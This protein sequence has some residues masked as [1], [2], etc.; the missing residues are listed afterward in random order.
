M[1]RI[2]DH[3][4]DKIYLATNVLDVIRDFIPE[5]KQRGHN[6]WALSP[7]KTEKTPSFT[8]NPSKGI[9]KCFS[10]GKGGNA[11]K[12]LMEKGMSYREAMEHLAQKYGIEIPKDMSPEEEQKE[13][14]RKELMDR[15]EAGT[16]FYQSNIDST[17][18]DF[19]ESRG[20]LPETA[21]KWRLGMG[22]AGSD[23][24]AGRVV[25]PICDLYGNP[26]AFGGR[27]IG[28]VQPKYLN[29]KESDIYQKSRVL[30]GM[31]HARE[32]IFQADL[33]ILT[34][35][36]MDVIM[37]HQ[38][39]IQNAIATCGTALTP[40]HAKLI[41]RFT[42]NVC[43]LRD[44]DAA[45][46][47]A[48]L[49]DITLLLA[50]GIF[51]TVLTLPDGHDPDSYLREFSGDQLKGMINDQARS[52]IEYQ[53]DQFGAELSPDQ[54][55]TMINAVA[56]NL[57]QIE[58]ELTF[59]EYLE[60]AAKV[61]TVDPALLWKSTGRPQ[62]GTD[63]LTIMAKAAKASNPFRR[64]YDSYLKLCS[65]LDIEPCPDFEKS[66]RGYITIRYFDPKGQPE[67][68]RKGKDNVEAIRVT[69]QFD[70][71]ES[72]YL[73]PAL[74]R[75]G[76]L[77]PEGKP[78]VRYVDGSTAADKGYD[79]PLVLVQDEVTAYLLSELGVPAIGLHS[80]SAFLRK[81]K[82]ELHPRI[83]QIKREYD[84]RHIVYMLPGEAWTL[85][86]AD[87]GL[88]GSKYMETDSA[89]NAE[90]IRDILVAFNES[91][92][93]MEKLLS[94][95]VYLDSSTEGISLWDDL[96]LDSWLARTSESVSST[97]GNEMDLS[98]LEMVKAGAI[99]DEF[100]KITA[101]GTPALLNCLDITYSR[102]ERFDELLMLDSVQKW[103]EFHTFEGLGAR[104]KFRK[105]IYEVDL[106]SGKV[107]MHSDEVREPDVVVRDG[108][109]WARQRGSGWKEVSNFTLNCLLEI[110]EENSY[111]IYELKNKMGMTI[112]TIIPDDA[113]TDRTKFMK[114]IRRLPKVKAFY[115]GSS[116]NTI[117]LQEI[118]NK[119]APEAE[120]LRGI[121]GHFVPDQHRNDP[122]G[123]ELYVYGNGM[124]DADGNF[125]AVDDQG[126]VTIHGQT[127]FLPAE[128][129]IR[130]VDNPGRVF[131]RERLFAYRESAVEFREWLD[132]YL[133]VHGENGHAL[134]FFF[135]SALYRDIL[136]DHFKRSPHC[137]LLGP[138]NAGKGKAFESIAALFGDLKVINLNDDP[139]SA[140]YR[141]AF[142]QYR[143]AIIALNEV[144]PSSVQPWMITGLKGPYD[145]QT[146]ARMASSQGKEIDFGEVTS[147]VLL[148]G[149][150]STIYFQEAVST[151]CLML[152]FTKE[153]Y[154]IE[155]TNKLHELEELQ[156][157]MGLGHFTSTFIAQRKLIRQHFKDVLP[158][159]E[160]KLKALVKN[161]HT[162]DARLFYNW[163]H[164]ITPAWI[165]ISEGVISYPM[166]QAD[167]LAYAARMI[168]AHA[169]EMINKGVL[170]I[171]FD[172]IASY[173]MDRTYGLNDNDVWHDNEKGH[174]NIQ[175][176][177]VYG[178]FSRHLRNYPNIENV[179]KSDLKRRLVQHPAF[180]PGPDSPVHKKCWLGYK[181]VQGAQGIFDFM[182]DKEG[183]PV[184]NENSGY[185]FDS[186]KIELDLSRVSFHWEDIQEEGAATAFP[187][188]GHDLAVY[189]VLPKADF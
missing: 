186:T 52:W 32:H 122:E 46:Q 58:D 95:A 92:R 41:K 33:C 180:V 175:L 148:M 23:M 178:K 181:R 144:N 102:P 129:S 182:K 158:K 187:V 38:E 183:Q 81:T 86:T 14:A 112:T 103:Y 3:I 29:S 76:K 174:I 27:A 85:P 37:C 1:S 16:R 138:K 171:F 169:A 176:T 131:E 154:T 145:N 65:Q 117:E 45:G 165:L 80:P 62:P 66:D 109:I 34:E 28:S 91:L 104:F 142:C 48:A 157:D 9:W 134:F 153:K 111:N 101:A 63:H 69:D 127:Y 136:V 164:T 84:I 51:P 108:S 2:P 133:S 57:K 141:A 11:V 115:S 64:S 59:S 188:N 124:L 89:K 36:Y 10:T 71:P 87:N 125:H 128:S 42:H 75:G 53:A 150:E 79:M 99:K 126:L 56:E 73:P 184:R 119:D 110:K 77:H 118:I 35:G 149:Q 39:G 132:L 97:L 152:E 68:M 167:I 18:Q 13:K 78:G 140:A 172:F 47:A 22:P 67:K 12:F 54:R 88:D 94:Y 135:L 163:A 170:E 30:Y 4:I 55:V 177:S 120:S 168:E 74:R 43:I 7:F 93:E 100:W 83:K 49:K 185:V 113:F 155:E 25:F 72:V 5:M 130:I 143:N 161:A 19:I 96:W 31:H 40:E 15:T 166:G 17:Y 106:R 70:K 50:H 147:S 61:L 8:V 156:A 60:H 159:I 162:V 105:K 160:S 20:I 114:H 173:Y 107:E 44:G 189:P 26:V 24:M 116:Q 6:W 82:K 137:F 146:R 90:K 21:E 98:D 179:T 151:R 123:K 121:L 139:T